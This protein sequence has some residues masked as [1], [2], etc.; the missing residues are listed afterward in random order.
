MGDSTLHVV[1]VIGEP[2][3]G[4]STVVGELTRGYERAV[5][6]HRTDGGPAREFLYGP[7]ETPVATE[8]GRRAGPHPEG[9]PGTD[10]MS[11]SAIVGVEKWL[12]S[13]N[14]TG[15]VIGEGARLANKRF[16]SAVLEAG[17]RLSLVHLTDADGAA[18][19]RETRGG[20][21]NPAWVAG[22]GTRAWKFFVL[23]AN[24]V[25]TWPGQ[26]ATYSVHLPADD[27]VK[28]LRTIT[29]LLPVS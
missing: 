7:G 2:G 3:V 27:A 9:F 8:L 12:L 19:R 22:Q 21:Q 18:K 4:K 14:A 10:A 16:A 26:L 17:G 20:H 25:N 29:G 23:C 6:A 28:I 15:L 5:V 11:M 13:G 1:Y 24:S